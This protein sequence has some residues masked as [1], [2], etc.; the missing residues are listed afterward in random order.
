MSSERNLSNLDR[1]GWAWEFLR[2]NTDY[3]AHFAAGE[4]A[5]RWGLTF[6]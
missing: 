6:S 5:A 2:R 3:Q 4:D 1:A